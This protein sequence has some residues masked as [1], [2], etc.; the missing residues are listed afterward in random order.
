MDRL[1][2]NL[3]RG[4]F[5]ELYLTP[6][7]GL[8]DLA[9]SGS[10]KDLSVCCM[11]ESVTII[12]SYLTAMQRSLDAEEPLEEQINL[13]IAAEEAVQEQTGT[14][15]HRGYIFLSGLL[16][17]ASRHAPGLDE[18]ALSG[19]VA[20][21]ALNLFS[22]T[23]DHKSNGSRA[24]QLYQV[25]GI[26]A[27]ALRGLPC[28]FNEALPAFRAEIAA[29]GNRGSAT[30]AMLARLMQTVEDTTALH[31]CGRL[32]LARLREDGRMLERLISER[33]DFMGFL[34]RLNKRYV[35]MNLTMGGV[36][37]LLALAFAWLSHTGELELAP[38]GERRCAVC[39]RKVPQQLIV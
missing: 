35:Q 32:G 18:R 16:L 23:A 8:V 15:C 4:A 1:T 12:S 24:R 27:E 14:N 26:K 33:D 21:T 13:G 17:C 36:A 25:G 34:D 2:V 20:D 22:R 37:D 5:L 28:L 38:S 10:H 29:E 7:P 30:F 11:E 9:D 3:V 19:A 6:K 31:R 39:T